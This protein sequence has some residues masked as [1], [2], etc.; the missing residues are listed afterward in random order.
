MPLALVVIGIALIVSAIRGTQGDLFI[1]IQQD[2]VGWIKW[3][4]AIVAVGLLGYIPGFEWPARVLLALVLIVI[5]LA[6]KGLF[7]SLSSQILAAAPSS[8]KQQTEIAPSALGPAPVKISGGGG[9]GGFDLG[10]AVKAAS[11]VA[12]AL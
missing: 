6:N 12:G 3:A 2:I 5:V 9:Q 10:G 11:A 1:L 8:P 4:A 7:S